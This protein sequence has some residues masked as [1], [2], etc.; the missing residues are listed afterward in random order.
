MEVLILKKLFSYA[1]Q[2]LQESN[3]KDLALVKLCLCALG[4]I[5]GLSIPKEKRKYPLIFAG[6]LFVAT[7]MPLMVKF[8][9]MIK[10]NTEK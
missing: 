1:D 7:F 5:I 4:V 6:I 8:F 10:R 2:Y 9:I 3:W